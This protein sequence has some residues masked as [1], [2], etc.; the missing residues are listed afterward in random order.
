MDTPH[1]AASFPGFSVHASLNFIHIMAITGKREI[2]SC[3]ND[4]N[5]FRPPM[6]P[7]LLNCR[8][9]ET[10]R[11]CEPRLA[12]GFFSPAVPHLPSSGRGPP[13]I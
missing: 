13:A 3:P 12:R 7:F 10:S 1:E 2:S 6:F 11:I 9:R 8:F 5:K 4:H